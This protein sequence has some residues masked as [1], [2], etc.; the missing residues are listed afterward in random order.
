MKNKNV[1]SYTIIAILAIAL[2]V[3]LFNKSQENQNEKFHIKAIIESHLRL[4]DNIDPLRQQSDFHADSIMSILNDLENQVN[5]SLK[6][7]LV[8]QLLYYENNIRLYDELIQI[9]HQDSLFLTM[10]PF[11]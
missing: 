10:Y 6:N 5:D 8:N 11:D 1:I 4:I 7:V 9:H 2:F 3:T